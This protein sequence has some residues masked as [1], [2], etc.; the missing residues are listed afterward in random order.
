MSITSSCAKGQL[1]NKNACR[2]FEEVRPPFF[3]D[4]MGVAFFTLGETSVGYCF[5]VVEYLFECLDKKELIQ[6]QK[7]QPIILLA[8][9]QDWQEYFTV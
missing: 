5:S 2:T 8:L 6:S 7:S 4:P 1:V 9:C 3:N